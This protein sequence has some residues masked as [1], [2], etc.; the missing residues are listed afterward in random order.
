[1]I[2]QPFCAESITNQRNV[3]TN[4]DSIRSFRIAIHRIIVCN[5]RDVYPWTQLLH[6]ALPRD[7]P[8]VETLAS[9][10]RIFAWGLT[11]FPSYPSLLLSLPSPRVFPLKSSY[12]Y[13]GS[14]VFSPSGVRGG[15]PVANALR[16]SKRISWQKSQNCRREVLKIAPPAD[17]SYTLW[18]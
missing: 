16:L 18:A 4:V 12:T 10:L 11:F 8:N 14:A 5:D 2:C 9:R 7:L 17:K 3:Y 13:R 15:A 6:K 1:M